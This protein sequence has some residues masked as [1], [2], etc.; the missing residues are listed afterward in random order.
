MISGHEACSRSAAF[1]SG[2]GFRQTVK[3]IDGQQRNVL[4]V[5][6][7]Y[8]S[9]AAAMRIGFWLERLKEFKDRRLLRTP[10]RS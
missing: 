1:L 9:D 8:D 10:Y 5:P 4:E 6:D 2:D 3:E 7:F